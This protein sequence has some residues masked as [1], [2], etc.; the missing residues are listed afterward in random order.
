[1]RSGKKQP[2]KNAIINLLSEKLEALAINKEHLTERL[3]YLVEI[4][5]LQNMPRNGV[6]S[7]YVINNESERSESPLIQTFPNIPII[8]DFSNTKVNDTLIMIRFLIPPIIICVT[9]KFMT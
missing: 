4:K 9:I 7:F 1:M 2:I 8:K 5:I 3:D 6:N